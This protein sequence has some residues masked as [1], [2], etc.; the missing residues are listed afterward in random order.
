MMM[1][2]EGKKNQFNTS[3]VDEIKGK[4]TVSFEYA[5]EKLT[6]DEQTLTHDVTDSLQVRTCNVALT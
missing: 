2:K 6:E 3:S 4:K 1:K 5:T